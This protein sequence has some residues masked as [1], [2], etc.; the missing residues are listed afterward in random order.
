MSYTNVINVSKPLSDCCDSCADEQ[1]IEIAKLRS[2]LNKYKEEIENL[3][4]DLAR[5]ETRAK[6]S[7]QTLREIRG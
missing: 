7:E 4:V 1:T 2:T 3:K 5:A 6:N